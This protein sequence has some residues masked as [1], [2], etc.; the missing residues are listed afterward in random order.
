MILTVWWSVARLPVLERRFAWVLLA[1]MA[2]AMF[3]LSWEHR[4]PVW[5]ILSVLLGL[6]QAPL[7]DGARRVVRSAARQRMPTG[8]ARPPLR[9]LVTPPL[10]QLRDRDARI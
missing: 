3:P 8:H 7:L 5:F 9:P 1:A 10:G 2:V 6:S 4:K